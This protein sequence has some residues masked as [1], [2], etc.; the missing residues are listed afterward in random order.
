MAK[1]DVER[2]FVKCLVQA[3]LT[4]EELSEITALGASGLIELGTLGEAGFARMWIRN[5]TYRHRAQDLY[6]GKNPQ[7]DGTGFATPPARTWPFYESD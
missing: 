1:L 6:N 2:A 3:P 4:K 5:E 7:E